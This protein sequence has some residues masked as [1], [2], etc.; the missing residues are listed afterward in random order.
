MQA[1]SRPLR[2]FALETG[3]EILG[4]AKAAPAESFSHYQRWIA[5]GY[6]AGMGY[7]SKNVAAREKP[8]SI[9]A[10]VKSLLMLGVS[11]RR[12]LESEPELQKHFVSECRHPVSVA[13]YAC[14]VDYHI[15]I[16]ERLK[17]VTEFH[18]SLFPEE[19][20][21]GVVDTAPLLERQ[22][23]ANAGLG[24]IGKN[25]MLIHPTLGSR[26][27][28]AALL[29]TCDFCDADEPATSNPCDSC[30]RCLEACPT[31][32]LCAPYC[33]DARKCLNYWTIEHR[34]DLPEVVREKLGNR[35]FG[36]ETCQDVCPWNRET[37][38]GAFDP[39]RI[40]QMDESEFASLFGRTPLARPGLAQLQ[41]TCARLRFV[42][43][44]DTM[45]E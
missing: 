36:C 14:G 25:T 23:A 9:L 40:M 19:K 6:H 35:V 28:L 16:R 5:E 30:N 33:L 24:V 2:E 4:I 31:G 3:F 18:R 29:S 34:G 17:R 22:Y 7:L 45:E 12:V 43:D 42:R 26:F 15:W 1:S 11:Y 8:D 20:C 32:A 38:T 39:Q 44:E 41:K 21:R 37:E 13:S 10:H 27:F